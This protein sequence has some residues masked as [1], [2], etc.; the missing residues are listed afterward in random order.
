MKTE[1]V[2]S[3]ELIDDKVKFSGKVEGRPEIII[4]YYEPVGTN[5]GYTSLELLQISLS[6]C[7]ATGVVSLLRKFGKNVKGLSLNAKGNRAESHPTVL[8][9]IDL[10]LI[11]HSQDANDDDI[12]KAIKMNE[13]LICPV[14]AMLSPKTVINLTYKLI[15]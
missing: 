8:N 2:T 10:E 9:N 4:D 3:I 12:T 14:Y 6:S 1:L 5:D 13:D 7:L 11:I 15:Q